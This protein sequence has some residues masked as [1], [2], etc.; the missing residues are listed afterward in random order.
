MAPDIL[1]GPPAENSAFAPA[2]IFTF[3]L[4]STTTFPGEQIL[5]PPLSIEMNELPT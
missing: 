4:D 2:S 5:M 3:A 1:T